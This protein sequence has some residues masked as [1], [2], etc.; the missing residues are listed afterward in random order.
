M[1]RSFQVLGVSRLLPPFEATDAVAN[2]RKGLKRQVWDRSSREDGW[3]WYIEQTLPG[4]H[5][6][7][8]RGELNRVTVEPIAPFPHVW[9]D[10]VLKELF[11]GHQAEVNFEYELQFNVDPRNPKK[12][13]GVYDVTL[14]LGRI[15]YFGKI[16]YYTGFF[17]E[18]QSA[19]FCI[20]LIKEMLLMAGYPEKALTVTFDDP[21]R[22]DTFALAPDIPTGTNPGVDIPLDTP[23]ATDGYR[24]GEFS[25]YNLSLPT[26][27]KWFEQ[28]RDR[29]STYRFCE[30]KL[31]LWIVDKYWESVRGWLEG[32]VPGPWIV[33]YFSRATE[34]YGPDTLREV[35][36]YGAFVPLDS[37]G[38]K[39]SG[40]IYCDARRLEEGWELWFHHADGGS[41]AKLAK[42]RDRIAELAGLPDLFDRP[43]EFVRGGDLDPT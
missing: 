30:P 41:P 2:L 33:G 29:M 34:R 16:H 11:E 19:A 14:R 12:R 5:L 21:D 23:F 22:G 24:L 17:V 28:L 18:H 35:S 38:L 4:F 43:Q 6:F 37:M 10:P 26:A 9:P 36:E 7:S 3:H 13:G 25:F 31:E 42:F 32:L 20:R 15:N 39:G 8:S 27:L 40:L 1:G